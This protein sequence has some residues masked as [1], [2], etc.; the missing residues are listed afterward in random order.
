M[1]L[2]KDTKE[3]LGEVGSTPAV[4]GGLTLVGLLASTN[5]F[6]ALAAGVGSAALV[7]FSAAYQQKQMKGIKEYFHLI[8][9][10]LARL[11]KKATDTTLFF[12]TEEGQRM[13]YKAMT[14]V[15]SDVRKEKIKALALLT[16]HIG[17]DKDISELEKGAYLDTLDAMN[18]LQIVYLR[19]AFESF[20]WRNQNGM[21]F[22]DYEDVKRGMLEAGVT[23]GLTT[24]T[25]V[26]LSALGLLK[27]WS[28]PIKETGKTHILTQ[29]GENFFRF[30]SEEYSAEV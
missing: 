6:A 25:V 26:A 12:S 1:G 2:V 17:L 7:G 21:R 24:Q 28:A 4:Q 20:R 22:Y 16:T 19:E 13:I 27:E 3:K 15:A 29:F 9:M 30:I 10:E 11:R 5:P 18:P 14:S 23:E 8:E